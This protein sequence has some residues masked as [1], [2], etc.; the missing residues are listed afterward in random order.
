MK[1]QLLSSVAKTA[2][3]AAKN[4]A[5]SQS[6][7]GSYEVKVPAKLQVKKQK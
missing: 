3:H 6:W 2:Q 7:W 1:K 5:A 4:A